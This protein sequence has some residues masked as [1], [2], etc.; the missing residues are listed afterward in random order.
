MTSIVRSFIPLQNLTHV[1]GRSI[2]AK[3]INFS[4][5]FITSHKLCSSIDYRLEWFAVIATSMFTFK[6]FELSSN[7]DLTSACREIRG[8]TPGRG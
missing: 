8:T 1:F 2:F 6:S 3:H 4:I 7:F 5:C